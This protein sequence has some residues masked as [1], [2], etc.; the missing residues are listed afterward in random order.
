MTVVLPDVDPWATSRDESFTYRLLNAADESPAGDLTGVQSASLHGSIFDSIRTGGSLKWEG[1]ERIDWAAYR[2]QPWYT[3]TTPQG[4]QKSWPL[5]VFIPETP[6]RGYSDTGLSADV[7]LFDK[8][9][10]LE[11]DAVEGSFSLPAGSVVT[12]QVTNILV[13]HGGAIVTPSA[14]TLTGPMVWPAGTSYLRIV[15]D[16][17]AA[18]NYFSVWA[19]GYGVFRAAPY[20]APAYRTP[21][22]DFEDDY[23]G[24]YRDE[25]NEEE[26]LFAVPN[27]VIL[28]ARTEGDA[29]PLTA[30]ATNTD[31]N[32]P[33]SIPRRA[34]LVKS[35]TETDVEAT[36]LTVLTNL[37][38]RRL[39]SLSATSA[40]LHISHA[41][42]QMEL[43]DAVTFTANRW[44]IESLAVLQ[45]WS[46]TLEEG[47]DVDSDLL[48]VAL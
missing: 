14:E 1:Q 16:L 48:E 3:F 2:I 40:K 28:I 33:A 25:F 24:V 34:G 10:M 43:N 11:Q 7:Q 46:W 37:A 15:N 22:Y 19:D 6:G 38:Q 8:M 13:L 21:A 31:P 47:A 27:K 23:E 36:S 20:V 45:S 26:D 35:V 17:L 9:L 4:V 32:H 41:P 29:A 42:I 12:Q 5:G 18:I 30:S 44:G 39:E